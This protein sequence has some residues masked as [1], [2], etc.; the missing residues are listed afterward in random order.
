LIQGRTHGRW[1]GWF[2]K[3]MGGGRRDL[4]RWFCKSLLPPPLIAS[5]IKIVWVRLKFP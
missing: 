5:W 3:F 4:Q 2:A 1:K